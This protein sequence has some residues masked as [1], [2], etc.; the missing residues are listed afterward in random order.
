[1]PPRT[2]CHYIET[3]IYRHF[4][5]MP[6]QNTGW[7]RSAKFAKCEP[8]RRR[9]GGGA[10]ATSRNRG[11]HGCQRQ[12]TYGHFRMP[13][14]V[15]RGCPHRKRGAEASETN[16]N[17]RETREEA[18]TVG[19][20]NKVE[21]VAAAKLPRTYVVQYIHTSLHIYTST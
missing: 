9:A 6:P 3:V 7:R 11:G 10:G 4:N 17:L 15:T 1:M 19:E 8:A 12:H 20:E 16:E 21:A 13:R 5:V 14:Y 2:L 18:G